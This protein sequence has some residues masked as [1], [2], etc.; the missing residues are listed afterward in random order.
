MAR[1]FAA[2]AWFAGP[3]TSHL[4]SWKLADAEE[5]GLETSQLFVRFRDTRTGAVQAEGFYYL[6]PQFARQLVQDMN[7]SPHPYG[8]VLYPRV[9]KPRVKWF[10]SR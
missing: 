4:H 1:E 6:E 2:I 9:V 7:A 3:A 10:K 5:F 8:E